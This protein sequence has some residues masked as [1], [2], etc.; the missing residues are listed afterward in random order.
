MAPLRFEEKIKEKLEQRAIPP[1]DHMWDTLSSQLEHNREKERS[2]N[3]IWW[4]SVA[5]IFVGALL[6]TAF[7][8][9]EF[10]SKDNTAPMVNTTKN[11]TIPSRINRIQDKKEKPKEIYEHTNLTNNDKKISDNRLVVSSERNKKKNGLNNSDQSK[12]ETDSIANKPPTST[13]LVH[14]DRLP[15]DSLVITNSV[16]KILAQLDTMEDND[17]QVTDEEIDSLLRQAQREITSQKIIR[18]NTI[19]ASALLQDVE[20]DIDETFKQRVFDALKSGFQKVKTAVAERE[21]E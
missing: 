4:Y 3:N 5:A 10:M 15:V 21:Y 12:L 2:V 7:M 1:S 20:A 11:E 13:L 14:D 18:S 6:F 16:E 8:N 9:T 17:I 19:S